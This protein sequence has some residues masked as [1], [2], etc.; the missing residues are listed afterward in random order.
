MMREAKLPQGTIR[1]REEGSGEPLLFVHGIVV[2]GAIWRN[3]VP[4]LAGEFRCICPDWPLGSHSAPLEPGADMSLPGLARLVADFMDAL[5]LESATLVGLDSGGAIVQQVAVDH[6]ERVARMV[7]VSCELYER[8]LPPLFKPLQLAAAVPGSIWLVA[9]LLRSRLAQ[10]LPLGY[11]F[12]IKNGLPDR[13]TMDSYLRPGRTSRGVRRDLRK[14]L[15]A[16]DPRYTIDAAV[17]LTHFEKPVLVAWAA[18]DKLFP[19]DYPRRFVAAL[20][21]ARLEI[22]EDSYTFVPEDQ[23]QALARAIRSFAGRAAAAA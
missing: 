23:P 18:Q 14:F 13:A 7:L 15:R 21:N 6:P 8:F 10:R 17:K 12:A 3:V 4:G 11:G 5:G 16:V 22:I 19:L 20:P 1:Y 2:N 9:Q